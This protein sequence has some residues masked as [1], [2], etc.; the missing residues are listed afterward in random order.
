MVECSNVT[1]AVRRTKLLSTTRGSQ[2]LI[3]KDLIGDKWLNAYVKLD[4]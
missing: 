2:F 3:D 1:V 4:R